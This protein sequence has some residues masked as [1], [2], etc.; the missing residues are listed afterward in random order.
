ME[1]N[2]ITVVISAGTHTKSLD[3]YRMGEKNGIKYNG[4]E[5]NP[6]FAIETAE[7]FR[8]FTDLC[9][10]YAKRKLADKGI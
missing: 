1:K 9:L 4:E 7:M 6:L 8:D 5:M 3:F 10:S 2:V